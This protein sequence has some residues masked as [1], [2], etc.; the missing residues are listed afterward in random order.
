MEFYCMCS[1]RPRVNTDLQC[2]L[3]CSYTLVHK[4]FLDLPLDNRSWLRRSTEDVSAYP[5]PMHPAALRR[6][7]EKNY[8]P[9][10]SRY[11]I[12]RQSDGHSDRCACVGLILR[13]TENF[14]GVIYLIS[15]RENKTFLFLSTWLLAEAP[16]GG[17]LLGILG[18]GLQPAVLQILTLISDQKM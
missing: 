17:V 7:R 15:K 18:E 16:G 3:S 12:S 11:R 13:R 1:C 14:G 6:T 4:W 5:A 2:D 10:R 9:R 8:W